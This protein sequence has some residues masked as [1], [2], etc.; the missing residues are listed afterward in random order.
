MSR[1]YIASGQIAAFTGPKHVVE[2]G[3]LANTVLKIHAVSISQA[4]SE[5]DDSTEIELNTYT[6]GGTGGAI[7]PRKLGGTRDAAF[8]GTAKANMSADATVG[9]IILYSRGISMLAG[10]DKIWTPPLRPEVAGG[11]FFV[12]NVNA[13]VTSVTLNYEIEFEEFG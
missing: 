3:A 11:E 5:V 7:T 8:G 1:M 4:T 6:T 2:L 12:V 13:A 10:F 9:E